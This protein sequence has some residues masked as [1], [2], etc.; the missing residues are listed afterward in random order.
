MRNAVIALKNVWVRYN[1]S[2]I[3][4]DVSL[5]VHEREIMSI[6]GPNG[7]G[8]S[9]LLRTIMG[10]KKPFRGTVEVLGTPLRKTP[11]GL[12]GYLPQK[13]SA[14]VT[15]PV[16]VFDVV[17]MARYAGKLLFERLT[18]EDLSHIASSLEAV[19]MSDFRDR[20]FGSLSEG[21]KQRVL[22]ARAIAM[23]PKILLLDE[24]STG[25]D[26]LAQDNFYQM[27]L[28]LRDTIGLAIV[29]VS[30]DIGAVSSIVDQLACLKSRLHFHG[31]PAD[32]LSNEA[33]AAVFGKNMSYV[34]HDKNCD[35]CR[36]D[37]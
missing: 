14:D 10:L 23:Q 1:G 37:E 36:G 29:M 19:E 30:H 8:K 9:T 35:S 7:S 20:H 27:L 11:R 24:P 3:L 15:M 18:G 5:T 21:Q 2:V 13:S 4:E 12:I 25:L 6:V 16:S 34:R 17:A 22:I 26:A 33:L 31:K 32:C 28:T